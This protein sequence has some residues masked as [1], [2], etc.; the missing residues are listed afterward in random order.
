[1]MNE[2]AGIVAKKADTTM[3][4]QNAKKAKGTAQKE[5]DLVQEKTRSRRRN[6]T[7]TNRMPT[8]HG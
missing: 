5:P 8:S 1:M 3:K 2:E 6:E 7:M 4:T